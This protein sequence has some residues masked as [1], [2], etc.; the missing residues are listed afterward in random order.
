MRTRRIPPINCPHC[1]HGAAV[2]GSEQV[3]TLIREV[4]Y[5][6]DNDDCG[7]T[8]VATIEIVR[9]VRPSLRPRAGIILPVLPHR[10]A[11]DDNRAPANDDVPDRPAAHLT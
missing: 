1:Q 6:C 9:T 3:T 7:H 10:P 11:N 4:R 8:F 5:R 2:R